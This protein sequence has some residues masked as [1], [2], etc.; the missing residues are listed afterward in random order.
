MAE[1]VRLTSSNLSECSFEPQND[2]PEGRLTVWFKSGRSYTY[3]G[4]P[5]DVYLGLINAE[6]AGRYFNN[7]IRGVYGA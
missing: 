7:V 3:D 6:S 2:S 1:R 4:V 5:E